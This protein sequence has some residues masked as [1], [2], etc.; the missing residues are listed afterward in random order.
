[1][2][3]REALAIGTE[4]LHEAGIPSAALDTELML[5][6][7]L[8]GTKEDL[9][10]S[11]ERF[12]APSKQQAF[13]SVLNR[14]IKREPIAYITGHKEFYGRDFLVTRDVLIPRPETE[15]LIEQILERFADDGHW[16]FADIGTGSGCLALT[17]A[18]EFPNAK[19]I[20]TDISEQALT[21][22]KQNAEHHRVSSRI[23]FAHGDLL[24]PIRKVG[25][26]DAIVANLPYVPRQ[27]LMQN[28]DLAYEPVLAL[29][30]Q[31]EPETLYKRILEQWYARGQR[32]MLLLEIHPNLWPMLEHENKK[33][34]VSATCI[35]DL[36]GHNRV[37]VVEQTVRVTAQ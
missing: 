24:E 37:V 16:V 20:A 32:P 22:T 4:R 9:L 25:T 1:M 36:A 35:K 2:T 31:T 19:I 29:S 26:I 8:G 17:L 33:I 15:H 6:T 13:A 11:P 34:G 12:L 3:V 30:G 14:R 10:R 27:E 7:I 21:V 18:L 23:R 28:P 5:A